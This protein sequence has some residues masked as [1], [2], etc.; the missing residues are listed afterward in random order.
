M[1]RHSELRITLCIAGYVVV[2]MMVCALSSP[3]FDR[4]ATDSSVFVAMGRAMLNGKV[5]YKDVFDHKG[6]YLYFLNAFAVLMTGKSLLGLFVVECVFMFLCARIVYAMLSK[7]TDRIT[8]F[9][10]MQI[11]M[12]IVMRRTIFEGGNLTEEYSLLFHVCAIYL[13][14]RDEGRHSCLMMML[15][16]VLAGITLCFRPN[17]MMMWGGIALVSGVDM[18]RKKRFMLLLGNIAA[19]LA[20]LVISLLPAVIYAVLNDSVNDTLFGMFGYNFVYISGAAPFLKRAASVMIHADKFLL[21]SLIL[22]AIIMFNKSPYYWA[23]LAFS[24]ASVCIS[25]RTYG[26]YYICLAVFML[27]FAYEAA[28]RIPKNKYKFMIP[29]VMVITVLLGFRPP[30]FVRAFFGREV[31]P[32]DEYIRCNE[33]YYSEHERVANPSGREANHSFNR[34][35]SMTSIICSSE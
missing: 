21:L 32:P 12:M 8:A 9:L 16:G 17:M 19:G 7:Y 28:L 5:V 13:V 30:E 31:I 25:G 1:H 10:A 6:L 34:H 4:T 22:S 14:V 27:P 35:F 11:F 23:M 18:L 20:G 26:H 33:P 15:Q 3:L 24:A 29:A 2:L